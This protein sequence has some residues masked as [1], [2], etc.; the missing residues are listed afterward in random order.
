MTGHPQDN[1]RK[2]V[3]VPDV[4]G[5]KTQRRKISALTA[6]DFTFARIVD[7]AGVDLVLVGDTLSAVVQGHTNTLPVTLDEMIYHCRCVSRGVEHA[8]LVGDMPF[9]SYQV[10]PEQA[11]ASAGRFLKE[12]GAG[13]VKLEGGVCMVE[14]LRRITA[15]DIPVMGHVGLTPQSYHRMGGHRIQGRKHGESREA[16]THERILQ[17]AIAVAEAG[18]FAIVLEGIPA[19]L[20]R[21]ITA[22]I[23]IPT[24]GIGAGPHW[25]GQ[26]LVAHDVLGLTDFRPRFVKQY[27]Q[28]YE[29]MVSALKTYVSE[30][31]SGAFP[32]KDSSL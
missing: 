13:A 22:A 31:I 18:A 32:A 15:A 25:D 12:G 1:S 27:L 24:I 26:I 20:A 2:R 5:A 10:S 6:Y 3:T 28:G 4:L 11:V 19:E 14:Q 29:L 16:G 9:M 17:D 8:L 30:V 23:D 21:E 7:A